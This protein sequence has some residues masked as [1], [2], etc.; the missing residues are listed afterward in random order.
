MDK[1]ATGPW[2]HEPPPVLSSAVY[3]PPDTPLEPM[4]FLSRSWSVSALEVSKA[5]APPRFTLSKHPN[6]GNGIVAAVAGGGGSVILEDLTSELEEGT[7]FSGNPFSFASSETSQMV[8]ERIMSQS[9]S[10][11]EQSFLQSMCGQ[12]IGFALFLFY[13]LERLKLIVT[14]LIPFLFFSN[15]NMLPISLILPSFCLTLRI[16]HLLFR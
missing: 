11:V 15:T 5:L 16:S 8:M 3:R 12:I 1:T 4:E 9:V 7:T 6:A 14:L 10:L 13:V 2:R